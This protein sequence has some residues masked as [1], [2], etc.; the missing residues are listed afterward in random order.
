MLQS[1]TQ[2]S[3]CDSSPSATQASAAALVQAIGHTQG[4][5]PVDDG[6]ASASIAWLTESEAGF[7]SERTPAFGVSTANAGPA[8]FAAARK[9]TARISR[10]QAYRVMIRVRPYS[11]ELPTSGRYAPVGV[12]VFGA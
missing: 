7:A 6:P 8:K 3:Q 4:V 5:W 12:L 1:G 11:N 9:V 10:I 2:E